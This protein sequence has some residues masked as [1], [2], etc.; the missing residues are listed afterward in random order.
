MGLWQCY[1]MDASINHG[2]PWSQLVKNPINCSHDICRDIEKLHLY[3]SNFGCWLKLHVIYP[4]FLILK[5]KCIP[6]GLMN[7]SMRFSPR[8][9]CYF[10]RP[11]HLNVFQQVDGH[12]AKLSGALRMSS[13]GRSK[14]WRFPKSWGYPKSSYW[15]PDLGVPHG[16]PMTCWN[17]PNYYFDLT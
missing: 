6:S 17:P 9:A 8:C 4:P 12:L 7:N 3:N 13:L 2:S 14:S 5:S 15:N 11:H 1:G 16:P 10:R